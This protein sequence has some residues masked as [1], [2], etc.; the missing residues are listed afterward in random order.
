MERESSLVLHHRIH[1]LSVRQD[2]G[3]VQSNAPE[4]LKIVLT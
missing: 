1:R 4:D 2:I 3:R